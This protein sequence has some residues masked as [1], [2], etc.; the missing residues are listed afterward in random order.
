MKV[1]EKELK[2]VIKEAV[3]NVLSEGSEPFDPYN[4][5]FDGMG[6][7]EFRDSYEDEDQADME[8]ELVD[9]VTDGENLFRQMRD[10]IETSKYYSKSKDNEVVK[11]YLEKID[12]ITAIIKDFWV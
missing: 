1:T 8:R 12:S 5:S 11:K 10:V 9:L 7:D 2:G 6:D 3:K 4:Y